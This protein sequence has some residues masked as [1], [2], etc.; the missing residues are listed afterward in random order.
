MN[1]NSTSNTLVAAFLVLSLLACSDSQT[2]VSSTEVPAASPP[3]L[4]SLYA[5]KASD[6]SWPALEGVD[7]LADNP[8]AAN[9][10]IVFDG[11]GSMGGNQCTN[12]RSKMDEAK[13]AVSQFLGRIPAAANVGLFVFDM[14][15]ISERAPLGQNPRA[16][17]VKII[18]ASRAGGGT[19]LSAAIEQGYRAL[20][21]QAKRQL[22]YG[23]Y[24][25]VVVTDGE[26]SPGFD[27]GAVVGQV[28]Q[29]SPVI[30]HTIGFCIGDDHS[31][32]QKGRAYYKAANDPKSLE[33]GLSDVLAE[34]PDFSANRF[35]GE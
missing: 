34:V 20:T 3:A 28:L 14:D 33:Q 26:A 13:A 21:T 25:L 7:K 35:G 19:P 8:L 6:N 30:L 4:T 1:H 18:T 5:L 9:F 23:Q 29:K 32:N 2:P 16:E 31:L 17:L 12:G 22:G 24:N 10:Y 27:P 11:S 15:G